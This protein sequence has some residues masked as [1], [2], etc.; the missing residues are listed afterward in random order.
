MADNSEQLVGEFAPFTYGVG[1]PER[2]RNPLGKVPVFGSNGI[3]GFH[4]KPLTS[5]PTIVIGRKGTIGAIH[6]SPVPCWPIDTTFYVTGP[7]PMLI[8][9][10]YYALLSLGLQQMNS[11][12][13]VPGLNRDA[14]HSRSVQVPKEVEQRAIAYILGTL[15]DKIG[16]NRQMNENMENVAQALFKNW[17][18][19]FAPVRAKAEGHDTA[20]PQHIAALFPDSFEDS[21][22]HEKKQIPKGWRVGKFEDAFNL[23]MGQSPPGKSYNETGLG[24]PFY[25]GRTDFTFRYPKRRVYCTT[26]T[27]F[28]KPGDTLVSVRAP[29]GDIN[30][31]REGCAIGRGVAAVRHKSGSRSF[32]FY[33]MRSLKRAFETFEAEGTVFGSINKNDFHKLDFVIPEDQVINQFEQLCSPCDKT[34]ENNEYESRTLADLRDTLLSKLISGELLIKFPERIIKGVE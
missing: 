26:P 7:D 17:F 33:S 23:V 4:D 27:R 6:Y 16:L 15:D 28:A 12:S 5:G 18:V 11:D 21:E 13:A 29:V 31:A 22:K 9:Y 24:Q 14:A 10:K 2:S 34:I 32:T 30:M 20:I 25:Q 8:R 19:D 1:L 3:I